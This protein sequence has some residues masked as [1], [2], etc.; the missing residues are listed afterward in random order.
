MTAEPKNPRSY[1]QEDVQQILQLAIAR[2]ADD[3]NKEFSFQQIL[4]I[5]GELDI[6]LDALK[7]A[8]NDWQALQNE[9]QQ[10]Q[11]FDIYRQGKFKKRLGNYAI[12]NT[13]L[14]LINALGGNGLTWSLY[15]LLI[16]GL[17]VGLDIWNTFLVKG[18]EYEIAFQK[19]HRQHQIKKTIKTAI[20]KWF[21]VFS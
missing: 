6:P 13:F 12:I 14:I 19:W 9:S 18:E 3:Q 5:A 7:L 17:V 1:S 10:R 8:E 21:K 15:I 16:S 11:N 4:E 2:Q 20:N